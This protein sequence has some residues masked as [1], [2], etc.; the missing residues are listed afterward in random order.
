ME[1]IRQSPQQHTASTFNVTKNMTSFAPYAYLQ[2][3]HFLPIS[4]GLKKSITFCRGTNAGDLKKDFPKLTRV[5]CPG[6][7]AAPGQSLALNM[8]QAT[9]HDNIRPET[10]Y[11]L[12]HLRIAV[13][14]KTTRTETIP[15]QRLKKFLELRLGVFCYTILT[16]NQ[17]MTTSLHQS[18][19]T[20]RTLQKGAIENQMLTLS[21]TRRCLG[22]RLFQLIIYHIVKLSRAVLALIHQ[23]SDRIAFHNPEFEPFCFCV[24]R[25]FPIT[26]PKRCPARLTI[27]TLPSSFIMPVFSE[28]YQTERT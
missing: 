15:D 9:L 17:V 14:C 12:D 1:H 4:N 20:P 26:P 16:G 11:C 27:P 19:D 24:I 3:I 5:T 7:S 2:A 23:L 28:Y 21:Q 22:R 6:R 10:P 13:N 8:D 18:H 25:W